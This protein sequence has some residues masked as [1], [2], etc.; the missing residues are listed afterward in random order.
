MWKHYINIKYGMVLLAGVLLSCPSQALLPLCPMTFTF[1]IPLTAEEVINLGY[2]NDRNSMVSDISGLLDITCR[3]S[4]CG[5]EPKMD[6]SGFLTCGTEALNKITSAA[7]AAGT[8]QA[9]AVEPVRVAVATGTTAVVSTAETDAAA[10]ANTT[11]TGT[12]TIGSQRLE[13]LAECAPKTQSCLADNQAELET[14][15]DEEVLTF[16]TTCL[17]KSSQA[18]LTETVLTQ[19]DWAPVVPT[20]IKTALSAK[21][22]KLSSVMSAIQATFYVSDGT[23]MNAQANVRTDLDTAR[24]EMSL[25]VYSNALAVGDVALARSIKLEDELNLIQSQIDEQDAILR[26]IRWT[27]ALA[28]QNMQKQNDIAG[29]NAQILTTDAMLRMMETDYYKSVQ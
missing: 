7:D 16:F 5:G 14:M 3:V 6:L 18:S 11:T 13:A 4:G 8:T 27:A 10:A 26:V 28:A 29:L 9:D 24:K 17:E 2:L 22:P 1:D 20:K 12:T 23:D 15:T 25:M 19:E 21:N